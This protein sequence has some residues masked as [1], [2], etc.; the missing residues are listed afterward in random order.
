MCKK[1]IYLVLVLGFAVTSVGNAAHPNPVGWWR[2]DGDAL[3]S[4]GNER[5]GTLHGNPQYVAGV[6]NETMEFDGDDYVTIDGYKGVLGTH[7]FS[8]TAWVK[9]TNTAIGQ[10]VHWGTHSDGQRVE[11]RI[12]NNRLRISGGGGNVQGNTVLTDGE[13]YH[14]AATVIENASAS[15]GDVTFYVD[16]Q[17]DTIESTASI[18]WDIVANPTLDVTIGW[19]PTQQDRP[20]IGSIDDVRIYDKELTLEEIQQAMEG[21]GPISPGAASEPSPADEAADVSRDVVLS[22]R[23]GEFA[24]PTNGHKVY[25]G[26]SFD[27]VND[28][29]DGIAQTAA[30]YALAQRLDFGTTYYWRVD[31]VN[32]PPTSHVEFKGEVWSF[33]TEPIG[34][35]IEDVNATA[36]SALSVDTGPENTVNGSG[37]DAD[38]L[39]SIEPTDMWLSNDEPNGAWIE[40]ELDKVYKLHEMWVWNQNGIMELMIGFGLKDVT[41][42]HSVNGTDYTT[43]GTTHE[44]VQAPG[45]SNY[46]HNTIVDF[47]GRDSKVRQAHS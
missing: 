11:F 47:G 45:T 24:A 22:W 19:R 25:F 26:E 23:P 43:L 29:T 12:N 8:I 3:D 35:P 31:E 17:E 39:H 16:G 9:T 6:F 1:L 10:I 2:F 30:S 38:D 18:R 42:E 33:T 7:A 41:I 4:S 40:Y 15:S 37:I 32:A 46:A 36:S 13:W 27:D 5:H 14:V 28:A 34:Y 44:F 21:I 20:F